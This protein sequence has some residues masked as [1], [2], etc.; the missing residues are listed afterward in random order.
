[1]DN[2]K[3]EQREKVTNSYAF[4]LITF[5]ALLFCLNTKISAVQIGDEAPE[6]SLQGSDNLMHTL[7]DYRGQI[8]VLAWFPKAFTG[9]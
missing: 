6:F 8:V 4:Q 2:P 7:S 3:S 5:W 1:M 9:G